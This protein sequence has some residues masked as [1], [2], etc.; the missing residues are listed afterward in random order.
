MNILVTGAKG[1]VG[2][3]LVENLRTF[4]D[5]RNRTRP[6]LEIGRVYEYDLGN[7]AEE[8]AAWCADCDFVFHLAGVN[9]PADGDFSGNF[10]A[11]SDVLAALEAAGNA[12][13]V[14][15]SSSAQ[16]TLSGR[17]AGSVYG[18]SKLDAEGLLREYGEA[19]GARVLIYRFPNLYGKW[20][21]PRYNSAVATFCDAFANDREF[22]VNDPSVELELL[23]IDDLVEEMLDALEGREHRGEDGI[24]YAPVTDRVTLGEIVALLEKFKRHSVDLMT[25]DFTP[26]CFEKKLYS[27]YLS[28]LPAE[29][30][31]FDLRM[32]VDERGSFTELVHTPASG[33]VSVNITKPGITKGMHWHN[34]KTEEFIVVAGEGLIRERNLRDGEVR[35]Y[36]VSGERIQSVI[37]LP[38]WT[39][40]ITNV[41]ECDLVTVMTCN[42]VFDASR[43]DTFFEKV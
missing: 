13:P 4:A 12:C 14:M 31:A 23:Y 21:R 27:M 1:F 39:H 41:G 26:G 35:E 2:R 7:T 15:L 33:Q 10:G 18:Q 38:G 34:T 5:G 22:T 17:F 29:K 25:P 16:A 42:E 11:L 20:C 28:Y 6:G 8:L 43:P 30:T 19:H 3:N 32:N 24:C 37:M 36:R 40:E 9:R